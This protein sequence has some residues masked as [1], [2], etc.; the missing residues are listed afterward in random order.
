MFI[1]DHAIDQ[2]LD[3][4]T[5]IIEESTY[6]TY[7][8][9]SA[10]KTKQLEIEQLS[11]DVNVKIAKLSD[12]NYKLQELKNSIESAK[13]NFIH[14]NSQINQKLD[15]EIEI[16]LMRLNQ[17]NSSLMTSKTKVDSI[18]RSCNDL[19]NN[20]FTIERNMN[21]FESKASNIQ[22]TLFTLS[23][24]SYNSDDILINNEIQ[25]INQQKSQIELQIQQSQG[26]IQ[27]Y[28]SNIQHA[29]NESSAFK[30]K[31][32]ILSN[33]IQTI[34][35]SLRQLRNETLNHQAT[36]YN[37]SQNQQRS[38]ILLEAQK[39]NHNSN[40]SNMNF[41][42]S[43]LDTDL[44][45]ISL[46]KK[47]IIENTKQNQN[48]IAQIQKS[49]Q[50]LNTSTSQLAQQNIEREHKAAEVLSKIKNK[51]LITE[52]KIEST[53]ALIQSLNLKADDLKN[54]IRII[55]SKKL[56][57]TDLE[58]DIEDLAKAVDKDFFSMNFQTSQYENV[59]EYMV[60][61]FE[62][63]QSQ[64][65]SAN[66]S[67]DSS[68]NIQYSIIDLSQ[69][70]PEGHT[71]RLSTL[72]VLVKEVLAKNKEMR[73]QVHILE[74][75]IADMQGRRQVIY[76]RSDDVSVTNELFKYVAILRGDIE[77]KKAEIC[78]KQARIIRKK[79]MIAAKKRRINCY[80]NVTQYDSSIAVLFNNEL[81][82]WLSVDD[83]MKTNL[84]CKWSDK[85]RN[86][87]HNLEND[88]L[89]SVFY[90]N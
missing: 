83:S 56:R 13:L 35:S 57:Q 73:K 61:E 69:A 26:N 9:E 75:R 31:Q 66:S 7:D 30:N 47:S 4:V 20:I 8:R 80:S 5:S 17:V 25:T 78:Q 71:E 74:R 16:E 37:R 11:K 46:K 19:Q 44:H 22:N 23:R 63:I 36:L 53:K 49:T 29:R 85:L 87:I 90:L 45:N 3:T 1:V 32:I 88:N 55:E 18:N 39:S 67:M 41:R 21:Q 51:K 79:R 70:T 72:H 86:L 27:N 24:A 12:N 6:S 10:V 42:L 50:D 82:K 89:S 40:L 64:I 34:Q 62:K 2:S 38:S 65:Q 14:E 76:S 81:M 77:S 33:Q 54:H 60:K 15:H 52:S 58:K 68:D 28:M 59:K 43:S 84:I 48:S